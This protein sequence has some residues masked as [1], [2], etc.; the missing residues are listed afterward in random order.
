MSRSLWDREAVPVG[1]LGRFSCVVHHLRVHQP[2]KGME[3]CGSHLCEASQLYPVGSIPVSPAVVHDF[4]T[5]CVGSSLSVPQLALSPNSGSS[6][7]TAPP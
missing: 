4:V 2:L 7:S 6:G 5:S 1:P 3:A